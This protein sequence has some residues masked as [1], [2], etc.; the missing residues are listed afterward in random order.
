MIMKNKLKQIQFSNNIVPLTDL[1]SN[2]NTFNLTL[3]G[4]KQ[5]ISHLHGLHDVMPVILQA[6]EM[7][8]SHFISS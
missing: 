6:I 1:S 8:S 2:L 4:R 5:N 7:H 3:C